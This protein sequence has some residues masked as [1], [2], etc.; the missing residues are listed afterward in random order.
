MNLFDKIASGYDRALL[1]LEL[2]ALRRLRHLAFSDIGGKVLELGVGTGVNLPLYSADAK[3]VALD[4]SREMID[5][6]GQRKTRAAVRL[7]Q[8]D[9][10]HLPFADGTFDVVTGSLLFCSVEDPDIALAEARR[11]IRNSSSDTGQPPGRL[12]LIEHMRGDGLGAWLTDLLN[13]L[14][15]AISKS[16]N[17]NRETVRSVSRAGFELTRVEK[18]GLGILRLIEGVK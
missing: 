8:A 1:P 2:A 4:A 13:P 10:Q 9:A 7:V 17:L 5:H 3:M 15:T 12:V 11:V 6:A 14:W 18:R 16:C